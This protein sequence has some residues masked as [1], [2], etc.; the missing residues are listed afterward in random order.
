MVGCHIFTRLAV[1][2]TIFCHACLWSNASVMKDSNQL[3]PTD[4]WQYLVG[5]LDKRR[6]DNEA[7]TIRG[8]KRN[9]K[10]KRESREI[11]GESKENRRLC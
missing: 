9:G 10:R 11:E 6:S 8:D 3:L 2:I 5:E 7:D 1:K 4:L